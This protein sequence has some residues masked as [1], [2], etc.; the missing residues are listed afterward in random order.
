MEKVYW[1]SRWISLTFVIFLFMVVSLPFIIIAVKGTDESTNA[2]LITAL[3]FL[4]PL[5]FSALSFR[6]L[7][8][9][10]TK[11]KKRIGFG[12]LVCMMLGLLIFSL[13]REHQYQTQLAAYE[14]QAET[15]KAKQMANTLRQMIEQAEIENSLEEKVVT[16]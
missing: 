1:W 10:E 8:K 9:N 4:I 2:T 11:T 7:H 6:F 13:Y 3:V 16:E 5:V 14:A 12:I 15:V